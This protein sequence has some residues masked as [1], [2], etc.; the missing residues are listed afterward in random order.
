MAL[1]CDGWAKPPILISRGR[2]KV[3]VGTGIALPRFARR[4]AGKE[5]F[6]NAFCPARQQKPDS[7]QRQAASS[8]L[9]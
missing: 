3:A 4:L 7:R 5:Q 1:D 2:R 9:R 8:E 6:P